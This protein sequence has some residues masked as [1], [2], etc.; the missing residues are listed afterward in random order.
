MGVAKGA[1]RTPLSCRTCRCCF[2]V[3]NYIYYKINE[4]LPI[5]DD[6]VDRE[7]AELFEACPPD[8]TCTT[9]YGLLMGRAEGVL[10]ET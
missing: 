9:R 8:R 2:V 4:R 7:R 5:L 6:V 3:N 1:L 10:Q